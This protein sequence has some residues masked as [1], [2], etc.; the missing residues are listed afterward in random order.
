MNKIPVGNQHVDFGSNSQVNYFA[1][2]S[3]AGVIMNRHIGGSALALLLVLA[4]PLALA[5]HSRSHSGAGFNGGHVSAPPARFRSGPNLGAR[6]SRGFAPPA[7]HYTPSVRTWARPGIVRPWYGPS[8]MWAGGYWRG[9]YWPRV[10][11]RS[12]FPLFMYSLPAVYATYWY[13]GVPYYYAH[14]AYYIWN[15][16]DGRYT[17]TDPPPVAGTDSAG[18]DEL[19]VYPRNGQDEAQQRLDRDECELWA[20]DQAGKDSAGADRQRALVACLDGRG[21][22]AK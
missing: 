4:S 12:S 10:Y 14:D 21:Y 22:T 11:Y 5:Q 1:S 18:S 8:R 7:R 2:Q 6:P 9:S 3:R 16:D 15:R 17:V 20:D 13:S 19:F